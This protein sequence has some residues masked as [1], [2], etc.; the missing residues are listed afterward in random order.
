MEE[1]TEALFS[2]KKFYKNL[3]RVIGRIE[4]DMNIRETNKKIMDSIVQ[5]Q[6]SPI[7]GARLWE[8]DTTGY[9]LIYQPKTSLNPWEIGERIPIDDPEVTELKKQGVGIFFN[10]PLVEKMFKGKISGHTAL[11]TEDEKYIM[12]F[13]FSEKNMQ[14]NQD[15]KVALEI[16]KYIIDNHNSESKIKQTMMEAYEIQTSILPKEIPKFFNYSIAGKSIPASGELIGGDFFHYDLINKNLLSLVVADASGHGIAAALMARDIH[17]ALHMAFSSSL[18]MA[19]VLERINDLICSQNLPSR[20]V[21]MFYGEINNFDKLIY[22]T[23]GHNAKVLSGDDIVT[24]DSGGPML[25]VT[26]QVMFSTNVYDVKKKD[27]IMM[28]TDGITE[29][30][31]KDQEMF[32]DDRLFNAVRNNRDKSAEQIVE[33][34]FS[35]LYHFSGDVKAADDQ[36]MMIIKKE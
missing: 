24:L 19:V 15:I 10:D 1:K 16:L 23:A 31:N 4:T 14:N 6:R 20:F 5:D 25:G 21:T 2:T 29:A 22:S 28:Y 9:E 7:V 18:K 8:L 33:A 11:I 27:I 34:V 26:P 3:E 32:G 30:Y 12:T 36:T 13:D 17:T 35:D